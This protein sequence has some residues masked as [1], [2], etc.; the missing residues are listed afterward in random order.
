MESFYSVEKKK[1]STVHSRVDEV[2]AMTNRKTLLIRWIVPLLGGAVLLAV[3]FYLY[4]GL[5]FGRFVAALQGADHKWVAIL[6]VMIPLEQ[7]LNGWKW[8]QILFEIRPISSWRLTGAMLAGYGANVLVPVGISPVVRSWLIAR[9]EN[10]SVAT[11]LSTTIIARFVDGIV[12]ALFAGLVALAGKVP[13]IEG[14]LELGLSIGGGLNILLFGGLLWA[15]FRFRALFARGELLVCR[16]FDRV[17][18]WF[19]AGGAALRESLCD[20]VVW[21][22]SQARSAA[23]IF[24]SVAAKGVAATHFLWA[25]LA[26]GVLLGPFDYIFLMVFAGFSMVLARFIRVPGGFVVGSA[27]ALRLLGVPEEQA[28]SMILF[29]HVMS[30][31]IVVGL[32]LLTLWQSGIDIRQ[33]RLTGTPSDV[34][35]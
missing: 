17:A 11:V 22:R 19:R 1:D 20:G 7:L 16:L 3:V 24:G 6:A 5:D 33:S 2:N 25:G 21:P 8:R 18:A 34:Q 32:G 29:S 4:R 15:M 10:L 23:V 31:L 13:R 27:F 35:S 9:L 30:I 14:N 28:L 26:V 12:F